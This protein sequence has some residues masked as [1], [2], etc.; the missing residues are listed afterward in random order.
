VNGF[1]FAVHDFISFYSFIKNGCKG[2]QF[3]SPAKMFLTVGRLPLT[4]GNLTANKI[5]IS[6][7]ERGFPRS[8]QV[9]RVGIFGT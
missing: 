1:V 3:L 4:V 2:E 9:K 8:G 7:S 5:P 6:C